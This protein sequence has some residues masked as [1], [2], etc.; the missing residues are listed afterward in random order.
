MVVPGD[1]TVALTGVGPAVGLG[2]LTP[3]ITPD[4]QPGKSHTDL[5]VRQMLVDY[6]TVA[7]AKKLEQPPQYAPISK[8]AIKVRREISESVEDLPAVRATRV[9]KVAERVIAKSSPAAVAALVQDALKF[10]T[11]V[12]D[13]QTFEREQARRRQEDEELLFIATIL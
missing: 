10:N 12:L 9:A 3:V 4:A 11:L 13:F 2:T 7:F 5:T 6:Y 8:P 1:V